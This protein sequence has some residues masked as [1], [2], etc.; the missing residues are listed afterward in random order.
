MASQSRPDPTVSPAERRAGALPPAFS[1][2]RLLTQ[3]SLLAMRASI[4]VAKFLLA[5]YTARYLGLADLGIYGLLVAGTTIVPAV[6]GLG[7]TD[8]IIRKIVDVPS[9]EALPLMAFRSGLTLSIHLLVQP[10]ALAIDLLLG[11]PV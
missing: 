6:A 3:I 7:M 10:L 9:A 11:E 2:Q 4:T 8:W 1:R 5:I